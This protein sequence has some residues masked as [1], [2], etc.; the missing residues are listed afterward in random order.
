MEG[1]EQ[2]TDAGIKEVAELAGIAEA[3]TKITDDRMIKDSIFDFITIF[4]RFSDGLELFYLYIDA[5]DYQKSLTIYLRNYF[6]SKMLEESA[7]ND[8]LNAKAG[9]W[10]GNRYKTKAQKQKEELLEREKNRG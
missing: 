6:R 8:Y 3:N 10:L 7:P 9:K 1:I 5:R 2:D 4:S